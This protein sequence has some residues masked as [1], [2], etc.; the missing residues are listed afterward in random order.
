MSN[1]NGIPKNEVS[2][3]AAAGTHHTGK[4]IECIRESKETKK[5]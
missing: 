1:S 3:T 5:M 2:A 4:V